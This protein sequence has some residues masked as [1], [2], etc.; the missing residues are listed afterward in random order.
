MRLVRNPTRRLAVPAAIAIAATVAALGIAGCGRSAEPPAQVGPARLV[1]TG[2]GGT[3]SVV[4]SQAGAGRIGLTTG[5]AGLGRLGSYAG[6]TIVPYSALLYEPDGQAVVYAVT[7]RLTYTLRFVIVRGINGNDVLV[8][9]GLAPG[10]QIVTTGG[11]ELL[12]VQNGV[13]VQT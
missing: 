2:A 1:P 6:M 9:A 7:G 10:T 8:S 11:E 12:G 13:G 5:Q 4:L 3:P